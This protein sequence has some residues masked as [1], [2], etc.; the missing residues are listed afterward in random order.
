MAMDQKPQHRLWMQSLPNSQVWILRFSITTILIIDKASEIET[1]SIG[2][3]EL[4]IKIIII[5]Q[6][7][8][9]PLG[10]QKKQRTI[11]NLRFFN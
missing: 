7:F 6:T 11:M 8:F 3:H 1:S 2:K 9:S 10:K 5:S 4:S